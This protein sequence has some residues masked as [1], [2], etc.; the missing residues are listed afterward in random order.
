MRILFNLF[1][2]GCGNNGG[3]VTL[4]KSANTLSKLGHD[5]KVIDGGKNQNTWIKLNVPHVIVKNVHEAPDADVIIATGIK[6]VD[7]TDKSNVKIK[8]WYI[9]GWETWVLPDEDVARITKGSPTLKIVNS[10]CLQNKL[11]QH[12]LESVIVYPGYDFNEIYPMDIRKN[13][14]KVILGG[15]FNSGKKWARKRCEWLI[16][17]FK[18]LSRTHNI[19]MVMFGTDF[20][21]EFKGCTFFRQPTIDVKNR[22][23]NTVDVW[24]APTMNEGL[25]IPPAEAGLTEACVV[26]TNAEMTGMQDYLIHNETGLVSKN[27]LESL[28][29]AVEYAI[30]NKELRERLG[31]NLRKKVLEIGDRRTN[32]TKFANILERNR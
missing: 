20:G 8:A 11:K 29:K 26:G 12:G 6:S 14:S 1:G 25:H 21:M 18:T 23:L 32:M 27:S 9:R 10:L 16:D 2:V 4:F 28:T 17:I 19:E 22:V 30:I 3:T 7:S 5:V 13:N 24:V 31:K 15:L